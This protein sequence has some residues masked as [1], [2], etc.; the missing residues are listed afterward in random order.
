MLLTFEISIVQIK[1]QWIPLDCK[2]KWTFGDKIDP[3]FYFFTLDDCIHTIN[4]SIHSYAH[5]PRSLMGSLYRHGLAN[6]VTHLWC[7]KITIHIIWI[8][9]LLLC[10]FHV[11]IC[12]YFSSLYFGYAL[13]L[14]YLVC[15]LQDFQQISEWIICKM[16]NS[17]RVL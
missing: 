5:E 11:Q 16:Q 9:F 7:I 4:Y 8:K 12:A 14:R 3:F 2:R 15:I 17:H 13:D 1:H 10:L 6:V